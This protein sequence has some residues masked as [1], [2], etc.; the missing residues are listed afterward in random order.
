MVF[1]AAVLIAACSD[2]AVP[3]G[4][5]HDD[6]DDDGDRCDLPEVRA[7]SESCCE[8]YGVDACGAGLFCAAFDERDVSTC[9]ANRT[10]SPGQTCSDDEHCSTA[11]CSEHG[12]C[13]ALPTMTCEPEWGCTG[14]EAGGR[15]VCADGQC[16]PTGRA[17][18]YCLDASDCEGY[19]CV[20]ARCVEPTASKM[21]GEACDVSGEC[22]SRN[23]FEGACS[24]DKN[25]NAGCPQGERCS[26]GSHVTWGTTCG[27]KSQGGS[28][29]RN[30]EECASEL[31]NSRTCAGVSGGACTEAGGCVTANEQCLQNV[32]RAINKLAGEAC[33]SA[34]ECLTFNCFQG[35]CSC[36]KRNNNG[37]AGQTCSGGAHAV[38]GTTCN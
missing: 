1:T 20:D 18:G 3:A 16:Q 29:C 26:G 9:Y 34:E 33:A 7:L 10:R 4:Q 38:W 36:D 37:C 35:A 6:D 23:C 19:L 31:C 5:N 15:Y 28:S 22:A 27:D 21:A 11:Q 17:S 14:M 30:N 8:S 2:R 24:C 32:C 12:F 25:S 13:A